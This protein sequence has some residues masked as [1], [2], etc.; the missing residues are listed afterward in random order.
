[1]D[2]KKYLSI[3][4]EAAATPDNICDEFGNCYFGT[5]DKEFPKM[6]F[7]KVNKPSPL[8]NFLNKYRLTLW[9]A[10]MINFDKVILL[11]AVCD[12]AIFGTVL[13]VIY[14]KRTRK[15][16]YWKEAVPSSRAVISDT[17]INSAETVSKGKRVKVRLINNLERGE[18]ITTGYANDK[19]A[20]TVDYR[21]KL[22]RVSKPSI[23]SIPFDANRP[24]Y[25]QKDLFGVEGYLE[26]N[27]ERFEATASTA[28]VIDDHRG[29]YPRKSHYDWL[30]AMGTNEKDG[31]KQY[32]GFNL[33]RNQSVNQDD[34]NEN[35][36]WLEGSSSRLTPVIFKHKSPK[37]WHVQDTQGMVDIS[38]ELGDEFV[39]KATTGIINFD[40]HIAFGEIKGFICDEDGNRYTLD[41]M[42]AIGEDKT[43]LF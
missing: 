40:Y 21:L 18:I 28:A 30:T 39:M 11:T 24:L 2:F 34:F 3:K 37:L 33:T 19:N 32:F 23:V 1:M 41:G 22:S 35:L 38:F 15:C 16:T 42:H 20:G 12:M 27:G 31:K 17:V 4:R 29:Y 43:L 5:F 10:A 25:S 36:L 6:D 9:E 7:L 8:P 14:D 13:T 26:F